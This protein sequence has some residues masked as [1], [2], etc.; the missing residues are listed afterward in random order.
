MKMVFSSALWQMVGMRAF[1]K[2]KAR[3]IS[4]VWF[5][6]F[7]CHISLGALSC[8]A[9]CP[10]SK[11]ITLLPSK[12]Y[13]NIFYNENSLFRKVTCRKFKILDVAYLQMK[14]ILHIKNQMLIS[15]MMVIFR[16]NNW[17][18]RKPGNKRCLLE[19]LSVHRFCQ[20]LPF[21]FNRVHIWKRNKLS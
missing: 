16:Y 15:N 14:F 21:G 7:W 10:K 17:F 18:P 19:L 8:T 11:L 2:Q 20:C 5:Y 12:L 6:Y 3:K 4:N 13:S 9:L 1:R